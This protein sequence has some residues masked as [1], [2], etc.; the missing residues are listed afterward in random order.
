MNVTVTV[1]PYG[2]YYSAIVQSVYPNGSTLYRID[3]K[4]MLIPKME[5]GQHAYA[6]PGFDYLSNVPGASHVEVASEPKAGWRE[7]VIKTPAPK[8]RAA[9]EQLQP[10]KYFNSPAGYSV[11]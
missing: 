7:I 6:V 3:D 10:Q 11:T 8:K 1:G 9:T 4:Y 2:E 5:R